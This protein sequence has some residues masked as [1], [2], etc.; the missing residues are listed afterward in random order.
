[1]IS[2]NNLCLYLVSELNTI[3]KTSP[4]LACPTFHKLT[5]KTLTSECFCDIIKGTNGSQRSDT[6]P[7]HVLVPPCETGL[8][9][10]LSK[11]KEGPTKHQF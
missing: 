11:H 9:S 6:T 1:M 8:F 4:L 2:S 3:E 5:T 7:S 10:S